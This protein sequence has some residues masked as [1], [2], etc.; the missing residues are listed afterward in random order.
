[1]KLKNLLTLFLAGCSAGSLTAQTI[2]ST[3]PSNKNVIMEELTGKTCQFCPDGHK[4]ANQIYT[5]NPGRVVLLNVH[6][7]SYAAGTPNY[8]TAWGDALGALFPV[9]GY[10]TGAVNRTLFGTVMHSRG[11]WT[12]N[13]NTILAQASPVNVGGNATINLD[14]RV[15]TLD[16]EAYYTANGPG[17]TNKFHA[18]ITQDNIAGPQTGGATWYPAMILPNGQYNHM[19]MVRYALTPNTGTTIPAVTSG[20]LFTQQYTYTVPAMINNIPVN[21]ADLKVAVYVSGGG[22]TDPIITGDE[23]NITFVTATPLG[24][25]NAA[26]TLDAS[27]GSVCG[28]DVDATMKVTNMGNTPLTSATFQYTVNG[29]TP[30]TY[31]HTFTN[32]IATG[33]YEDVVIPVTGLTPNGASSTVN[34]SITELNGAANPGTNVSNGHTV[35]T[36]ALRSS[37]TTTVTLALT[38]DQ[39]G[40]ETTWSLVDETTGSTVMQGGPYT[41]LGASGTTV[42]TPV[43]GTLINGHCYK[44]IMNDAYGDGICCGYGNGSFTLTLGGTTLSSGSNFGAVGGT[45]F[46]FDQLSGITTMDESAE[47]VTIMPNPVRNIMT[48]N[49]TVA[50]TSDLGINIYNTL[51][52]QVKQVTNG[53]FQGANTMEISTDGLSSGV[54]FLNITSDKGTTTKRFVVE[55]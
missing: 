50:E 29:G 43:N 53:S 34:L 24:A 35:S 38:T 9:S 14:T 2:V 26:A 30:G 45:K 21:L 36:A 44:F 1:M 10:P 33:Q 48:L 12:A 39:Y 16:V 42:R 8:R 20:S 6:T 23:A 47:T 25:S 22:S 51:G 40:S 55:K 4:I 28:T 31:N 52:Q 49:F 15:L 13:A 32:P 18:I 37:A 11:S 54:Y 3:T 46:V 41:D 17:T 19:H 5:N 7:G 27:L